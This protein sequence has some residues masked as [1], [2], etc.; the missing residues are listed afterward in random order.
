MAQGVLNAITRELITVTDDTHVTA[1]TICALLHK[2]AE[3]NLGVP[4]TVF[5]DNARYQKRALF[6]TTAAHLHLELFPPAYSPNLNLIERLW[7]FVK[8]ECLFQV[9]C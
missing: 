2:L 4:V 1:E 5:S 6:P 8:K 3:L 9:L 7:K